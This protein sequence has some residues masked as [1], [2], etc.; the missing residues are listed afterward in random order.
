MKSKMEN[1]TETAP[2]QLKPMF[3]AFT[4]LEKV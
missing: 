2:E 1:Y 4:E 3:I